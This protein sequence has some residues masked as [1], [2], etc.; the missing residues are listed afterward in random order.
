MNY[1]I[2][3]L[4]FLLILLVN[5]FCHAQGF[6]YITSLDSKVDGKESVDRE[7]VNWIE[8]EDQR[9]IFSS[10]YNGPNGQIKIRTSSVPLN[11]LG[12]QNKL[13][14][15]DVVP[16][17][18]SYGNYAALNQPN[19]T[20][21]NADGS[22]SLTVNNELKVRYGSNLNFND[23]QVNFIYT[24]SNNSF[25]GVNHEEHLV[26][27]VV[28]RENGAKYNYHLLEGLIGQQEY[29]FEEEI[30]LP[31]G[32]KIVVDTDRGI[33]TDLGWKGVL[34]VKDKNGEIISTIYEAVCFDQNRSVEIGAYTFWEE[35][36]V[37]H[38]ETSISTEWMNSEARLFPVIVDP[39]VT[40]PTAAWAGGFIPSCLIPTYS[41]DSILVTIPANVTVTE[42]NVMASYYADPFAGA[43]MGEGSMYFSTDCN[44]SQTFTVTGSNAN[45]AGTAYLEDFNLLNPIMCCFPESCSQQTFWLSYHL[46][47]SVNGTGCAVNYIRYEPTTSWP[48][49]ATVIG[50]TAEHASSGWNI[51][52]APICSDKC[53]LT[54]TVYVQYGVAPYT[55]TH[56]WSQDTIVVGT[57]TGCGSGYTA[58]QIG[59]TI[60]NCPV[61]CDTI[62]T[63]LSVPPPVVW[64]ACGNLVQAANPESV[65]LKPTPSPVP[66]YDSIVCS[67][68][69]FTID[70]NQCIPSATTV[71]TGNG[72]TGWSTLINHTLQNNG[73]A[74]DT[75]QYLVYSTYDG[76]DS[77]TMALNV[78]VYPNPDAVYNVNPQPV[79]AGVT[80]QFTD[81]S[82]F[83]VSPGV[84]WAYDFGDGN[85]DVAANTEYL[86]T[87]P[88]QYPFCFYIANEVGCVDSLCELLTVVPAE[89]QIP[90]VIT[91]EGDQIN[92]FLEFQYLD[93]YGSNHLTITN[94]WGN[95]IYETDD[96]QNDWTLDPKHP[97]GVYFFKLLIKDTE[98]VYSGYFHVLR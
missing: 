92:D 71:W 88:G 95:I 34:L 67:G 27:E 81:Q 65:N 69:P 63:V 56:P 46:G 28:F 97:E 55:I 64:D 7:D 86:Y 1:Y 44:N 13:V 53:D 31:V 39:I 93:F 51:S 11:Y 8:D 2:K 59:I 37:W 22:I 76:C 14:P 26:R 78:L 83:P 72:I 96:Y 66:I 89:L 49:E 90:N 23:Q 16:K 57:N 91:A 19:P 6:Q 58:Q 41:Q 10:T 75:M 9:S 32:A 18:L 61:Y 4:G 21:F 60:P 48:F 87:I 33:K 84:Y 62:N 82:A 38:L 73:S 50:H 12:A 47:R 85:G 77:D 94:R 35:S 52:N 17:L 40:G 29:K 43:V 25:I 36:G 54:G 30:N 98:A 42:L 24:Q 80:A 74:V 45:T 5:A 3:L 15:I 20:F 68:N 70:L 79:I